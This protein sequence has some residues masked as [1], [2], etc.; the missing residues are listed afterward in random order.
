MKNKI[1]GRCGKEILKG[2]D[3]LKVI[4]YENEKPTEEKFVHKSCWEVEVNQR[5]LLAKSMN[6]FQAAEGFMSESGMF[7]KV[8]NV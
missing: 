5:E 4:L 7:P 1:C 6:M 2:Q 3:Y 8:V